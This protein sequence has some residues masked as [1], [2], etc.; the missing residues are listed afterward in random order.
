MYDYIEG[1]VEWIEADGIVVAVNGIGFRV[2][3][4]NPYLFQK[5]QGKR[6][7]VYVHQHVREDAILLYGFPTREERE[8]FRK[9]LDV[10]GVGPK[11]ALGILATG[12]P[13]E[14]VAAIRQEDISYL[15]KLPGVGKK[16]AQR[17]IL[18]LKDKLAALSLPGVE[19]GVPHRTNAGQSADEKQTGAWAEALAALSALGYR[20]Q[21]I[22]RVK[23][24]LKESLHAGMTTEDLVKKALSLLLE[25][26]G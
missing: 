21:E 1:T 13:A 6:V 12:R 20:E 9:L 23:P 10:T 4:G 2:F 17:I 7:R 22:E 8:L 19:A 5:E 26:R 14:L 24:V 16:T 18:D 3:C 25:Y 15:T 11:G